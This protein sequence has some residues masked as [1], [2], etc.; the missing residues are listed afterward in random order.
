MKGDF[1]DLQNG[2]VLAEL[3][4]YGDGPYCAKHGAGA[5]LV[6]MGT[7]VIDSSDD[8]PYPPD[9]VFMPGRSN[10]IE[11]L[12]QHVESAR[13]SGAKVGVSAISV[14]LK[15][16]VEFLAAAEEAGADYVSLCC[17][18][19]ME[20]FT[21]KGLGYK[22]YSPEN[23]SKLE[24]WVGEILDAVSVP[25]IFKLIAAG[26]HDIVDAV[27][28]LSGMGVPIIHAAAHSTPGPGKLAIL[29]ELA[30][31]SRFLM[32][33]GGVKDVKSARRILDAGAGAIS[34]ATAAMKDADLLGRLQS[35]LRA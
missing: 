25:L 34:V 27:E 13:G 29:G 16:T 2:V 17:H 21:S 3:G 11:Y 32:G 28:I 14:E 1:D 33:G 30:R 20:M 35:E 5:S 12:R 15:D 24:T 23:R 4:G 9:F 7:Y 31:R 6:I 18:S 8:V 19:V 26:E 22:L 10:Y